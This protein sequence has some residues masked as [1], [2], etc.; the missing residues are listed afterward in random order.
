VKI[1]T[2]IIQVS[3]D[4]TIPGQPKSY[5][6]R[7]IVSRYGEE[8]VSKLF[9]MAKIEYECVSRP[10]FPLDFVVHLKN[11]RGKSLE[12]VGCEVK[13]MLTYR[14]GEITMRKADKKRKYEWCAEQG[15]KPCTI[16]VKINDY[17]YKSG[18]ASCEIRYK[19]GFRSYSFEHCKS[20]REFPMMGMFKGKQK[21]LVLGNDI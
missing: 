17:D 15:L 8:L 6:E 10:H 3:S 20:F 18:L 2:N 4:L 13:T 1:I 12:S 9:E 11:R 21:I 19:H 14:R 5:G 16:M 7:Q